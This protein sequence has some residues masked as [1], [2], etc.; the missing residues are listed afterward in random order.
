MHS[1]SSDFKVAVLHGSSPGRTPVGSNSS[2][3]VTEPIA[4]I[5]LCSSDVLGAVHGGCQIPM[6]IPHEISTY[7]G[8]VLGQTAVDKCT[9]CGRWCR[10]TAGKGESPSGR[11]IPKIFYG[12]IVV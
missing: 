5:W 10:V 3:V 7:A 8:Y 4:R 1:I 11:A 2:Y 9:G 12:W 6:V